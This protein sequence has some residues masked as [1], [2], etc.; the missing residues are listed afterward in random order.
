MTMVIQILTMLLLVLT[1]AC[2]DIKPGQ[3][4]KALPDNPENRAVLAKQYLEIMPAKDL[5]NSVAGRVSQSLP[6][7]ERK[8]FTDIMGSPAME[9]EAHG[10]LL[11]G[12][13]K[14]FTTGE[15]QAMV[16]FY[17]SPEGQSSLKKFGPL[18]AEVMPK[19]QLEVKK[20]LT[21]AQKP[22]ESEA[23]KTP[24]EQ[25]APPAPKPQN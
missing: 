22:P 20:A 16:T 3:S 5:L 7:R 19:I 1:S 15:M 25:P 24:K 13:V 8:A 2:S 11:D 10:L 9:K 21:A 4:A 12:L 14:H 23:P 18:M 17:G 6:E